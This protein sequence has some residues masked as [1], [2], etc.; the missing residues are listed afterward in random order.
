MTSLISS[1]QVKDGLWCEDWETG[2]ACYQ[3]ERVGDKT[4][5]VYEEGKAH[6]NLWTMQ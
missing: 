5:R 4:F 1:W 6:K 2:S 3:V